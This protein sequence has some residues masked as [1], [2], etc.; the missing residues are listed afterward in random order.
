[1]RQPGL[2]RQSFAECNYNSH[3]D[4]LGAEI[5]GADGH[6][7]QPTDKNPQTAFVTPR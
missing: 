5:I 3:G 4:E 6:R 2:D 7:R 1:L